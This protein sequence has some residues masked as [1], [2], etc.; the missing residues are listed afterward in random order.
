MTD[1]LI[2]NNSK[3]QMNTP[4]DNSNSLTVN[5]SI[6]SHHYLKQQSLNDEIRMEKQNEINYIRYGKY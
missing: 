1:P 5:Q 2:N 4:K 6:S 3:D